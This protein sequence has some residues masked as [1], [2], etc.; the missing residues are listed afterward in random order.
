MFAFDVLS[1]RVCSSSLL[2][3]VNM[4]A[5]HY[6]IWG[7]NFLRMGFHRF[8]YGVH[9]PLNDVVQHFDEVARLFDFHFSRDQLFNR[10]RSVF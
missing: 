10:L 6:Q 2:S 7:G 3:L 1:S 8:N 4:I 5:S 9:E